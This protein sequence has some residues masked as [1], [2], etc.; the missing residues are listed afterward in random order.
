MPISNLRVEFQDQ[1]KLL[2]RKVLG[3]VKT[4]TLQGKQLSGSL[5][6]TLA[7]QYVNSINTGSVPNIQSA[8]TYI[9]QNECQKAIEASLKHYQSCLQQLKMPCDDSVFQTKA[10]EARFSAKQLF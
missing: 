4:K 1:V 2:R 7:Q 5:L 6:V 3:K 10:K 8:W 9:C